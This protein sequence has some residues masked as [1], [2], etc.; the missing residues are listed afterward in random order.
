MLPQLLLPL[1]A[2]SV[3]SPCAHSARGSCSNAAQGTLPALHCLQALQLERG[4]LQDERD[5]LAQTL[6]QQRGALDAHAAAAGQARAALQ[7]MQSLQVTAMNALGQ[8]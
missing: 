7:Q 5:Q 1:P 4:R 6:Q 2:A 8:R 3:A